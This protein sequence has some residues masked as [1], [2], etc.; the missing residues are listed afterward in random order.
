[1]LSPDE[2]DMA[3]LFARRPDCGDFSQVAGVLGRWARC[4]YADRPP[5]GGR[6]SPAKST[7]PRYRIARQVAL[8]GCKKCDSRLR[9]CAHSYK[10]MRG[11]KGR[12]KV[13]CL[14]GRHG[15]AQVACGVGALPSCCE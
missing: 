6:T 3:S 5:S 14:Y 7:L 2:A 12:L 13:G 15:R 10:E 4:D 8:V 9:A 1:M 11:L